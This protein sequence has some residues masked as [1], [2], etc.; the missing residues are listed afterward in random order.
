MISI[1]SAQKI[2]MKYS[3]VIEK[4]RVFNFL[5]GL[6]SDLDEVKGRLSGIK[7]FPSIRKAFA[8]VRR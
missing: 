5:H 4:E 8:K 6:N 7:P 3:K 1:G 2:R